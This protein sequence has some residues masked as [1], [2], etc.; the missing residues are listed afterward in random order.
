MVKSRK[1]LIVKNEDGS[2]QVNY[3]IPGFPAYC[4]NGWIDRKSYWANIPHY[5]EDIEICAV[6]EGSV[7]YVVNGKLHIVNPGETI[8]INSGNIHYSTPVQDE[9][10]YYTIIIDHPNL[11]CS[12]LA[13][14]RKAVLPVTTNKDIDTIIFKDDCKI[15]K[16]MFKD[17]LEMHK[18][19]GDEFRTTLQFFK[20]WENILE[21]CEDLFKFSE[22]SSNADPH[23]ES[24]KAMLTFIRAQYREKISLDDIANS[25]NVSRTL[26]NTIFKKYTSGSPFDELLRFRCQKAGEFLESSKMSITEIAEE[27]GFSSPNYLTEVFKRQYGLSPRE[28]RKNFPTE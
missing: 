10:A 6:R 7:G 11:L 23:M 24:F 25:G 17:C 2:E 15:G 5:H 27:T 8:I 16:K 14:E 12:S 18:Y 20:I 19:I 3:D 13:V 28:Y 26:C 1:G 21:S 4:Y 9:R 22:V